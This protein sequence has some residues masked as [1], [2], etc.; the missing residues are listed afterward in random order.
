MLLILVAAALTLLATP[1]ARSGTITPRAYAHK[2]A[3][4]RWHS[5]AQWRSLDAIVTPESRW[6]PCAV[7]PSMHDC[8]YT[9]SSSC[10]IPQASPCPEAWRGRLSASWRAQVRWLIRYVA[11]RYGS[12]AA[13]L[14][15]RVAHN[16]Y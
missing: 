16:W 11:R 7:N 13:A 1:L 3:I 5:E 4:A 10:G 2:L 12:P 6:D 8:T 15:F 9:G 14:A